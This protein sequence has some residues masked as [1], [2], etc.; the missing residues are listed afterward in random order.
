MLRTMERLWLGDGL[1]DRP[2]YKSLFAAPDEDSG[3]AA[4]VLPGLQAAKSRADDALL[5]KMRS[6]YL[7]AL[8]RF[9]GPFSRLGPS[10][11]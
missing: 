2:F 4:W 1:P 11:R 7:D 3:Y 9:E 5:Q 6:A 8:R 10:K